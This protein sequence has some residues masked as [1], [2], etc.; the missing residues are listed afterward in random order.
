L[1]R[2]HEIVFYNLQ[3]GKVKAITDG[4][5]AWPHWARGGRDICFLDGRRQTIGCVNRD[6]GPIVDVAQIPFGI[7]GN[8]FSGGWDFSFWAAFMPG[9]E[10]VALRNR[11]LSEIYAI[12]L[13]W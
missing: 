7:T 11:G 13:E 1:T 10:P 12:Q 9:D 8:T 3:T 2:Q 4:H 6:G 5:K